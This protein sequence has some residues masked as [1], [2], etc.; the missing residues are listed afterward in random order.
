VFKPAIM[1]NAA[2]IIAGHC[3]PSG[4]VSPSPEDFTLTHRLVQAGVLLGI[5]LLDHLI[6]GDGS[7]FSFREMGRL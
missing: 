2:A 7:Y 4:D 6:I 1:T 5:E 3:H